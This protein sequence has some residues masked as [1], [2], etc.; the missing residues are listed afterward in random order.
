M[1]KK[2][3]PISTRMPEV[4]IEYTNRRGKRV[5]KHFKDAYKARAFYIHAPLE[6]DPKVLKVPTTETK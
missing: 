3:K 4:I 1:K 2:S 6:A 5:E